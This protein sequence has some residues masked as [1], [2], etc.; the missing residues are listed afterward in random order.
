M[1]QIESGTTTQELE[2]ALLNDGWREHGAPSSY[3][4]VYSN[5]KEPW[6]V[7]VRQRP[8]NSRDADFK[9]A[10]KWYRYCQNN[11]ERNVHVPRVASVNTLQ[12]DDEMAYVVIMEK[13]K[14]FDLH[15]CEWRQEHPVEQAVMWAIMAELTMSDVIWGAA[16]DP[17]E[18]I[19]EYMM[20]EE[21][22]EKIVGPASQ[23]P[24]QRAMAE[25]IS[26]NTGM[27]I[28]M[29]RVA[30]EYGAFM[31]YQLPSLVQNIMDMSK[32]NGCILDLSLPNVMVR[33]DN[34]TLVIT[35]PVLG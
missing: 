22:I 6:I 18:T 4:V 7:K 24:C 25:Y 9:C 5:H 13:L 17:I 14:P 12:E 31:D 26:R 23:I 11:W 20:G 10:M 28:E 1:L 3:S 27:V 34:K 15:N 29:T 16:V 21:R 35:D 30:I 32:R 33:P 2:I 19:L 8:A